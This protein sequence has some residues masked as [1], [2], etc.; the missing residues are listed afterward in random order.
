MF[1]IKKFSGTN[2]EVITLN[3]FGHIATHAIVYGA[4]MLVSLFIVV[5]LGI[6]IWWAHASILLLAAALVMTNPIRMAIYGHVPPYDAFLGIALIAG[7]TL[8]VRH[9]IATILHVK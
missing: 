1:E 2:A 8:F 6:S 5:P 4:L 7:L 3:V 9:V